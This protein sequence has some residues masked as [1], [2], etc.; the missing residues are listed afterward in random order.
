MGTH[1]CHRFAFPNTIF[2]GRGSCP[3]LCCLRHP[4]VGFLVRRERPPVCFIPLLEQR[5]CVERSCPSSWCFRQ[6]ALVY[7]Y[8]FRDLESLCWTRT[9]CVSF[10]FLVTSF[11]ESELS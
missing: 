2:V 10:R 1:V 8:S 11:V 3:L 6:L 7:R 4:V 9:P 5:F